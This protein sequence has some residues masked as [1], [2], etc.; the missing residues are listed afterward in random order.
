VARLRGL[1]AL[2]FATVLM[3]L[4]TLNGVLLALAI[5]LIL[6][7][8]TGLL[9]GPRSPQLKIEQN[10][11]RD[12]SA[13]GAEVGLSIRVT[14][15]GQRLEEVHLSQL[16]P[17]SLEVIK[18]ERIALAML[19]TKKTIELNLTLSG[20][21]GKHV[22][23]DILVSVGEHF[24]LWRK[25]TKFE[26]EPT[27]VVLPRALP[28]KKVEI[29]PRR[30]RGYSGQIP[31]RLGGPGVDFFGLR[32]Y[33]PGDPMHWIDWKTSARHDDALF[34]KMFEQERVADITLILDARQSSQISGQA[35]SLL[36]YSIQAVAALAETFLAAGNRV[37]LLVYGHLLDWTFPRYGKI[38]SE[39]ILQ[40]L[41]QAAPGDSLAFS[42]LDNLPTRLFTP[43]SQ[44]V[45]VGPILNSD[46]DML[47]SIPARSFPLLVISPDSVRY[48][49]QA[50][51]P[52]DNL[53]MA[54]RI[55]RL[56][57][58]L[59]LRKLRQAGVQVVDWRVNIPFKQVA[60]AHLSRPPRWL[61]SIG[62]D[63]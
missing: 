29:R 4:A 56:E 15:L 30:T 2:T 9:Y 43:N 3:G 32:S 41:A 63:S 45:F 49:F 21:R 46:I 27:L 54:M 42:K 20:K 62:V 24:N 13:I 36:E 40:K 57:R 26:L 11:T 25:Q 1:S 53:E 37:G 48:A 39:R 22:F 44:V 10:L 51:Q 28:L 38:Q 5:P 58:A 12:R 14:N 55:A 23:P 18:G 61:R 35:D 34:T 60:N 59:S 50:R 7:I 52:S 33:E 17:G 19:D 6:F 16:A 8:L 31:T 47:S